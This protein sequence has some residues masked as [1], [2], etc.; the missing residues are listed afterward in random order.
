MTPDELHDSWSEYQRL[1]LAELERHNQ[2][3]A[4]LDQK[5][6]DIRVELA[7]LKV[8]SGFWGALAGLVAVATLVGMRMLM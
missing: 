2:W 1:V 4:A 5:L 7:T 8:R 6:D 3:L